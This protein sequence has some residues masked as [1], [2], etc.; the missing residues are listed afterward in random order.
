MERFPR[1][2][3]EALH[4]IMHGRGTRAVG[5]TVT[6]ITARAFERFEPR[7]DVQREWREA[8]KAQARGIR[9]LKENLSPGQRAQFENG[10]YFDV[11][12]GDT[13]R[14]YRIRTGIQANILRLDK[15]GRPECYL[16]FMPEGDLV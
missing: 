5:D 1:S 14:R 12:G 4:R 6:A 10:G 8:R 13:G 3:V 7:L 16:C 9:L 2:L 11:V 15:R